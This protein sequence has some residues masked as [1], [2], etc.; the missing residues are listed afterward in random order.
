MSTLGSALVL[1]AL[2]FAI[3][4]IVVLN[5]HRKN[6]DRN[7]GDPLLLY[8]LLPRKRALKT[9]IVWALL[10]LLMLAGFFWW[11]ASRS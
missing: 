7:A 5:S 8:G 3:A 2:A 10:L 9:Q 1:L 11:R 4:L 6:G